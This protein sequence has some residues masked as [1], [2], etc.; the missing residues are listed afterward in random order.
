LTRYQSG[1]RVKTAYRKFGSRRG[2]ALII[3]ALILI[4]IS[5]AACIS[6]YVYSTKL[7]GSL[8][9][10]NGPVTM[11]NLRI[12]AYNW[13]TLA[14][15]NVTV[16][17]IGT[18]VLT[19]STADWVV[20]GVVQTTVAGCPVTL[21]PGISC[22]EKITISGLTASSGIVYVVKVVLRDGAIFATSVIAG[23]VTGQTGVP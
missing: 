8:E 13:N 1:F 3:S 4:T 16:R 23:Q 5:V 2:V 20:G 12:E 7:L 22:A 19:M 10:A 18:N 11:D 6:F 9:G 14:T 21:A 17:N 15:L